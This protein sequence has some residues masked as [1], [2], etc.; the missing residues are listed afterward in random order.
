M[1]D[2]IGYGLLGLIIGIA[3]GGPWFGLWAGFMVAWSVWLCRF[4]TDDVASEGRDA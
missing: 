2:A 1:T 4:L 3:I